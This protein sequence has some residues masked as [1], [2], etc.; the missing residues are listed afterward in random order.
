MKRCPPAYNSLCVIFV[1]LLLSGC[2]KGKTS[3]QQVNT[4]KY[5]K[6]PPK[7]EHTSQPEE[8]ST[9]IGLNKTMKPEKFNK[10]KKGPVELG[11][12][13]KS[14]YMVVPI[15]FY[16]EIAYLP[17]HDNIV[18]FDNFYEQMKFIHDNGY[19]TIT[20][21]DL[22][23][24]LNVQRKIP[25]KAV[26]LTF[27]GTYR[28][29]YYL[30]RAVL[31]EFGLN[32]VMFINTDHAA[33]CAH[34][35]FICW[36]E[37]KEAANTNFE[38]AVDARVDSGFWQ[39]NKDETEEEY[40]KR[41]DKKLH[42]QKILLEKNTGKSISFLAYTY[43]KYPSSLIQSLKDNYGYKA[44]VSLALS[45]AEPERWYN[46]FFVEPFRLG[47]FQISRN[48]NIDK[49]KE[50]LKT[51]KKENTVDEDVLRTFEEETA[52]FTDCSEGES[53]L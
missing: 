22:Y 10:M 12:L 52:E 14:G 27:D 51:F 3:T 13:T 23:S 25:D 4:Q 53:S 1:C 45:G 30:V 24:F 44:G 33:H 50:Y 41:L 19:K 21:E 26:L 6:I 5:Q 16:R 46:S 7:K 42:Y 37:I 11:L 39:K 9:V 47:S 20:T 17:T 40:K 15:V 2:V 48:T 38:I 36:T 49:F 32:A 34:S 31:K 18:S 28:H 29:V 8:C 43:S 35:E